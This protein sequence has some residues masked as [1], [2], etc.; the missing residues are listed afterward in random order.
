MVIAHHY[1]ARQAMY[2]QRNTEARLYNHCY[3][4]KVV[5]H[6]PIVCL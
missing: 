2:V 6:I 1:K 5:L 4:G 3:N